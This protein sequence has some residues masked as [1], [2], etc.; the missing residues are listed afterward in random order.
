MK[1]PEGT[2]VD[3]PKLVVAHAPTAAHGGA[4]KFPGY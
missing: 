2:A 4:R 1:L 3:R